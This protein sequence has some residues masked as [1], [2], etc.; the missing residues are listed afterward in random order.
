MSRQMSLW[1]TVALGA[2]SGFT[3]YLGLP[4]AR[5]RQRHVGRQ[6]LLN[7]LALGVILFLIWDILSKALEQIQIA[8]KEGL[9]SGHWGVFATLMT[10]LIVG[11]TVG[12]V[13]LVAFD[14]ATLRRSAAKSRT[15]GQLAMMIAVGLGLHNFSEGLAIGQGAAAGA[16]G[17]ALIL[18][19]G[20]GLHNVTEGFGIA[21]PMASAHERPSWG[22][23]ATAG[24]IGGGPTFLGAV[25]GF[26][27]VAPW[28][29][30][31]FLALAAGALIY[32][33]NEMLWVCRRLSAPSALASGILLGFL[34][35]FATDLV[36]TYAG[37]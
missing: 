13:G 30:V 2:L 27:V 10:M 22:F 21:A 37:A 3:V 23:L 6:S 36:L 9:K 35:A 15:P 20:F 34:V 7:A 14:G 19:V 25:I 18:I 29:F 31:L 33:I 11:L 16:I 17:F 32:V 12:L 24:L 8:L 28:A 5:I 1:H 4:V 26:N